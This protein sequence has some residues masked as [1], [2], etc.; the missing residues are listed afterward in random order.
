MGVVV[1][2]LQDDNELLEYFQ[3][4]VGV[5]LTFWVTTLTVTDFY[6]KSKQKKGFNPKKIAASYYGMYLA[7]LGIAAIV[8]GVVLSSHMSIEK[9]VRLGIGESVVISGYDILF[10]KLEPIQG[11][12]FTAM[13]GEF[14]VSEEGEQVAVMHPEKRRYMAS[15]QA[16]TEAAIDPS[17]ARDI[18]IALGEPLQGSEDWAVRIYVK[19]FVRFIWFGGILM[20][21]GGLLALSDKR[22]RKKISRKFSAK[23]AA[24]NNAEVET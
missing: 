17:L 24:Q 23:N 7:H 12:N 11:P 10:K 6:Y 20:F 16:M 19:P 4:L 13:R 2:I 5:F 1:V 9:N 15:G 22:Y 21:L 8:L 18:Y 3:T 14:I